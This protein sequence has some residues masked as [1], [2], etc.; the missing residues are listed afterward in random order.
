MDV[1]QA[2]EWLD[3]YIAAWRSN[4]PDD[5]RRLFSDQVSYR[6]HPYDTPL[7]GVEE[8]VASWL[9]DPDDPESWDAHYEPYVVDG[10]RMVA[11]GYSRYLSSGD[12]PER[13]YHNCYL[14][15]FDADGQCSVF[16]E[17]FMKAP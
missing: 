2:Q 5:I 8:L 15:E 10:S 13:L 1:T 4:D 12:E 17:Y 3:G 7:E 11:V 14:V 6:Y 9:A 16:T